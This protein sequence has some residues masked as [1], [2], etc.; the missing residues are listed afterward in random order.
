MF[1]RYPH[2]LGYTQ[3]LRQT[4]AH[5]NSILWTGSFI[6]LTN[7]LHIKRQSLQVLGTEIDIYTGSTLNQITNTKVGHIVTV[8]PMAEGRECP[9]NCLGGSDKA[10]E[11]GDAHTE[12]LKTDFSWH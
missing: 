12:S 7:T 11:R 8:N 2:S 4:D 9:S 5:S 3:A 10:S 1:Q 6:Q